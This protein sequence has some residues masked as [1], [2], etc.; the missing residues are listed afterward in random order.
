MSRVI[1]VV[2]GIL[3]KADNMTDLRNQLHEAGMCT[4]AID[5]AWKRSVLFNGIQLAREIRASC[6]RQV[7]LVGHSQGGLVCRVAAAALRDFPGLAAG[8]G[9]LR[10]VGNVEYQRDAANALADLGATA[11]TS[12]PRV[13]GV[14]TV[15][16]PNSGALTFGQ[17]SL[18]ARVLSSALD[19]FWHTTGF[20]N[21]I[22]LTTDRLFRVLQYASVRDVSY[23]SMSGSYANRFRGGVTSQ[24]LADLPIVNR[25]GVHLDLPNDLIVEDASVD[26]R[27]AVLPTEIF[28]LDGQYQ[29]IR[30]FRNCADVTHSGIH[31]NPTVV[32]KLIDWINAIP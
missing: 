7:V 27:E 11:P 2:H 9:E 28:D 1:W 23:L 20:D 24:D 3:S 5:Y 14:A 32:G 6:A 31:S 15:A 25:L 18:G 19:R 16:T 29:H 30:L 22:E 8:I 4:Y 26:M 13:V 12:E 10:L 21:V 17:L